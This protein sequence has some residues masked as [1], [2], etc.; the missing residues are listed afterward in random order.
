MLGPDPVTGRY[1]NI[2]TEQEADWHEH[3]LKVTWKSVNVA[4]G[5][6]ALRIIGYDASNI[7]V[8]AFQMPIIRVDNSLPEI[9]LEVIGTSVGAVTKC[10]VI[11]LG[12]DRKIQF[13]VTSYDAEGHV[14]RYWLSGT[15]GKVA[16]SAGITIQEARPS[17]VAGWV[18]V[19]DKLVE[20]T[21]APLPVDLMG[22]PAVAYNFEL[23]VRGLGTDGYSAEPVSQWDKRES[24]LVVSEP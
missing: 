11:K 6:Y 7:E 22:C 5:Y 4:N 19:K 16:I 17:P 10:G 12:L 20:F 8:G 3:D 14:K 23:H 9:G 21:V 1:Q 24:N 15:R 18:G 2:D 13:K